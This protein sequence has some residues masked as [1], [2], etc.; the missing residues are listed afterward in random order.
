MGQ[1]LTVSKTAAGRSTAPTSGRSTRTSTRRTVN[2][3]KGGTA[4][5]NYT[6]DVE[7][8][9]V[10]DAGWT[11]AA[12]SPS[13][14]PNDWEDITL[15][16]LTD[17]G[18][19]RRHLHRRPAG[20][21]VVPKSGTLDVDYSCTSPRRRPAT[22]APT[23]PRRPGT[24]RRPSPR[25]ARPP[26]SKA[27]H[28]DPARRHQQDVHVTDTLRRRPRHGDGHRQRA[29]RQRDVHLQPRRPASAGTCTTYNNTAT[30]TETKQQPTQTVDVCVGKDLTVDA[31]RPP[32]TFDRDL[33]WNID[34]DVD[35]THGQDR[36]R[37]HGDVQLHRRRRRRPASRDAGWTLTGKITVTNPN[38]WEDITLTGLTDAVD[39]GGDLRGR[40]AGP[41]VDPGKSG[42]LDARLHLHLRQ[43]PTSYSGTNTATA[44]WDKARYFTPTGSA[45]GSAAFTLTQAGHDQQDDPRH[46]HA[47][48]AHLGTVT[49]TD[50][51]PSRT[52]R[53]PTA[54]DVAG[55]GRHV[56]E[57]RQHRHDHR[58][59]P[60][61]QARPSTVCV[62]K[63]LTVSKTAAGPSTAPTTGRS[64]RTST[65]R[66]S[67]SPT[68]ALRPSTTPSTSS[69]PASRDCG[70]TLT[71]TITVTNPNDWEDITLTGLTDVVDNG[72]TCTVDRRSV[73]RPAERLGRRRLHLLPTPAPAATAAPTPPRRPGTRRR[74]SP[75]PAT[76]SGEQG[77]HADPGSAA[78]NKTIHVTDSFGGAPRHA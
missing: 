72:G 25:P 46:R 56:H 74:T 13:A 5:F 77:L 55:V 64:T 24:R 15:T 68:A 43:T 6:V 21:Y 49:A 69:R 17:V 65:R 52:G 61:R 35:K 66:P 75:R 54:H 29:V 37:R 4:T 70:W 30:I 58:D 36:R 42:S 38:D 26:G 1:D 31:R 11:L 33:P 9:G 76:A 51:A 57:V 39:N 63:D 45:S 27:V 23:P 78:T 18:R 44:T 12:R 10:T 28:A 32:A 50:G 53:S 3:A 67:R 48:A 71:G 34:K 59:R 8:T 60:V 2:I 47:T 41:Y 14:N 62:G 40:P 19:Q 22:A 16:G 20:P 73:R 7:Q